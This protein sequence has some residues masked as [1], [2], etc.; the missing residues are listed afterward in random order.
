MSIN[1]IMP[2]GGAGTRFSHSGFE[3]PK[4]LLD[5]NGRHFFEYAADSVRGH[6]ELESLTFVILKEH[7]LRF[8]LDSEIRKYAPEARIVYLNQVL[9]GAVLTCMKGAEAIENDMPVVFSDC[10]LLFTSEGFYKYAGEL[11]YKGESL[12]GWLLTFENSDGRF[13]YVKTDE[14]GFVTETA[15]KNPISSRAVCGSY[16]FRNKD[17][18]LKYAERYLNECPYEEYFMS[19]VYNVM[20]KDNLKIAEFPTDRFISFGTPEEYERAKE[21]L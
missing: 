13:S 7:A 19:G 10:D 15:E 6:V 20:V 1:L 9:K 12:D 16:G 5:L 14:N 2:M 3:C 21:I 17:I 4:P 8:D 18:F 11:E